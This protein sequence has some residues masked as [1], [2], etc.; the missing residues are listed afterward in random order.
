VLDSVLF[1]FFS[2]I[3][4]FILFLFLFVVISVEFLF[5]TV[6]LGVAYCKTVKI[7]VR[8]F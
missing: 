2:I 8:S 3:I 7:K 4:E 5:M 1:W 6:L